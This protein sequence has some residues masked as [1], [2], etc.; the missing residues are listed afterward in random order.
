MLA[1]AKLVSVTIS[2]RQINWLFRILLSLSRIM[3]YNQPT[4]QPNSTHAQLFVLGGRCEDQHRPYLSSAPNPVSEPECD[5]TKFSK[6]KIIT[7]T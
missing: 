6:E 4:D 7:D 2:W 1:G 5:S 3:Y